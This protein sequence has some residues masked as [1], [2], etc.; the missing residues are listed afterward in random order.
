MTEVA[1]QPTEPERRP[2]VIHVYEDDAGEWRW[3]RVAPNG[4]V[5]A[6]S[7]EGYT[8]KY[9]AILAAGRANAPVDVEVRLDGDQ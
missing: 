9:D 6:D 3:R 4:R 1:E 7:G 5:L 2:D 8:S